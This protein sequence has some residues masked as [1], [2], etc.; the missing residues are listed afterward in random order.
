MQ[1]EYV[2][3]ES[4]GGTM[5]LRDYRLSND[6]A[7]A[8]AFSTDLAT[9][10]GAYSWANSRPVPSPTS[11]APGGGG[12]PGQSSGAPGIVFQTARVTDYGPPTLFGAAETLRIPLALAFSTL[13][14]A[15]GAGIGLTSR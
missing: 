15:V 6:T 14:M 7:I 10:A 4:D 1:F 9:V 11:T 8:A 5:D 13:A 12:G 2:K 3:A